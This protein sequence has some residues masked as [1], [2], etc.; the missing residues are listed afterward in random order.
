MDWPGVGSQ[1]VL[2]SWVPRL[3][4]WA[5]SPGAVASIIPLPGS[6]LLP[7]AWPSAPCPE[8]EVG[9]G[10]CS[11]AVGSLG[12]SCRGESMGLERGDDSDDNPTPGKTKEKE[13]R[14]SLR[15]F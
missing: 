5:E 14:S 7:L 3:P 11:W 9:G 6:P 4:P 2:I 1:G 12:D 8:L 15:F 10:L 13:K